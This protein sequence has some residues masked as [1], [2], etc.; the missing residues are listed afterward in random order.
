M[1]MVSQHYGHWA[2]CNQQDLGPDM[3]LSYLKNYIYEAPRETFEPSYQ[4]KSDIYKPKGNKVYEHIKKEIDS[5]SK[6]VKS[7][8]KNSNTYQVNSLFTKMA[9]TTTILLTRDSS[10][11]RT[12]MLPL[13][14]ETETSRMMFKTRRGEKSSKTRK[15]KSFSIFIISSESWGKPTV[16]RRLILRFI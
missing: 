6:K 4:E 16:K 11:M 12:E 15:M 9:V 10:L 8:E 2:V 1:E 13:L 14:L 3:D 7:S 5:R